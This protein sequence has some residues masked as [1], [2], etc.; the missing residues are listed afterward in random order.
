M[1]QTQAS[2]SS[3]NHLQAQ[4]LEDA[5]WVDKVLMSGTFIVGAIVFLKFLNL[6]G[7][8]SIQTFDWGNI[9]ISITNVWLIFFIFLLFTFA[10]YYT[11]L[12]LLAKSTH[13]LWETN[14]TELSRTA[15]EKVVETGGV[16][17]RGLIARTQHLK[18]TPWIYKMERDDPS[19]LVSHGA[20]LLLVLAIV[21]WNFSDLRQFFTFLILAVLVTI[22]NWLIGGTWIVAL[23]ELTLEPG[24][25]TYHLRLKSKRR[26]FQINNQGLKKNAGMFSWLKKVA[27]MCHM[28]TLLVICWISSRD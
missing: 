21:P 23:S 28:L 2:E 10:H 7:I 19:T 1:S 25:A 6:L 22:V 17:V 5:K 15:F 9:K 24:E 27:R 11:G 18:N 8:V 3:L 4:V 13:K 26:D 12:L 14:S 16:Y 20:A